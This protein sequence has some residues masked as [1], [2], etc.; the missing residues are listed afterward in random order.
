MDPV[1]DEMFPHATREL[2]V[3]VAQVIYCR[4]QNSGA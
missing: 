2:A 1:H 3:A 4:E